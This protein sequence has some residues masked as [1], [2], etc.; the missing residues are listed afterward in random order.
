M[1][2]LEEIVRRNGHACGRELAHAILDGKPIL[3]ADRSGRGWSAPSDPIA[4]RAFCEAQ[5]AALAAE[6]LTEDFDIPWIEI[7]E[8]V[9]A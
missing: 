7:T 8:E 9:P 2:C 5:D 4:L 3:A 1:H 6:E